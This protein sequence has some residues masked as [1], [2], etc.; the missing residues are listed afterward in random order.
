MALL[1]MRVVRVV[2]LVLALAQVC[3]SGVTGLAG[4]FADGGTVWERLILVVLHPLAALALLFVVATPRTATP[5][6]L[7]VVALLTATVV[8][9]VTLSLAIAQGALKGDWELPLVLGLVPA[10]GIV[11]TL[12]LLRRN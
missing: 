3:L 5:V 8:A 6:L 4:A 10:I 7:L 2:V 12:T 11:Y 9:D 1:S